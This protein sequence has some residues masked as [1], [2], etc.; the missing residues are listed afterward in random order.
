MVS[1]VPFMCIST[2]GAINSAASGSIAESNSPPETSLIQSAP[3]STAARATAAFRVSTLIV[4]SMPR[5][6][7][8]RM[9]GTTR[10]ISCSTDTSAAP[11]FVVSPPTSMMLAPAL[12][13]A[14]ALATASSS[15]KCLPPSLK[16][17]GVT[18]KMPMMCVWAPRSQYQPCARPWS[19]PAAG[20]T[21][22]GRS[23]ECAPA[24]PCPGMPSDRSTRSSMVRTVGRPS[25]RGWRHS[26]Q[27]SARGTR[28]KSRSCICACGKFKG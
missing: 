28:T 5:S 26:G 14:C 24:G 12:T 2:T 11:G 4:T 7:K 16:L 10:S 27:S 13:I 23:C 17:S 1:G 21:W 9:T 3:A 18:F 25:S 22:H 20:M 8:A 19:P 6:R 15:C